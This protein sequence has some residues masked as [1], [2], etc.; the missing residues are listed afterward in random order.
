[1]T[2]KELFIKEIEKINNKN[3]KQACL[4]MVTDIPEYFWIVPASSSGKYH[5]ECDLGEGGLVRHSLMVCNVGMDLVTCE[6][7]VR[8]NDYNRDLVRVA[9]LFHDVIKHGKVNMDDNTY[10]SHTVFEHPNLGA[11]F[12]REH[13]VANNIDELYIEMICGA[14]RTHMGK[15][16]TSKYSDVALAKPRT[17]FEKLVH[18][19]DYVASRKYIQALDSWKD[20]T[21]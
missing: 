18:L 7:F 4:N 10:S 20:I 3:L 17:D 2:F 15:W 21:N 1:M 16:V 8:D 12:V 11:D 14:I 5:P 13:L 9:T 19:A 6:M